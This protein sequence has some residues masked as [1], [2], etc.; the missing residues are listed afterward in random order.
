M[1]YAPFTSALMRILWVLQWLMDGRGEEV[2]VVEVAVAFLNRLSEWAKAQPK[3]MAIGK[4]FEALKVEM[5]KRL[6]LGQ[7]K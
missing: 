2:E 4:Q 6:I 3:Y 5:E 1:L 7:D